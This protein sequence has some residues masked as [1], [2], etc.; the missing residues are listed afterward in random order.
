MRIIHLFY[1]LL[2]FTNVGRH[3]AIIKY[4]MA[5]SRYYKNVSTLHDITT[6]SISDFS[7]PTAFVQKKKK[8]DTGL[9]DLF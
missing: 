4:I 1:V 8:K 6:R 3:K 2:V 7:S 5:V 9:I